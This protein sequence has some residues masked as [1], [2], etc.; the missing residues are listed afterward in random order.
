MPYLKYIFENTW[1]WSI[2]ENGMHFSNEEN[3]TCRKF[4]E[5]CSVTQNRLNM[6]ARSVLASIREQK[7]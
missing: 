4:N 1:L 2:L 7:P 3:R 6:A 5:K